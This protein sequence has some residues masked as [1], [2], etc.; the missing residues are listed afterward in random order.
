MKKKVRYTGDE[1]ILLPT[2]HV[3]V[4]PGDVIEVPK[5]FYNVNFVDVK[6]KKTKEEIE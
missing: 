4:K 6:E 2:L 5:D 1:P 3:E